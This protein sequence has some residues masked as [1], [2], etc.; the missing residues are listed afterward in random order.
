MNDEL[1]K[2]SRF[3]N[4]QWDTTGSFCSCLT[5]ES[6]YLVP[7]WY[8][9]YGWN[10]VWPALYINICCAVIQMWWKFCFDSTPIVLNWEWEKFAH[11]I[12][13]YLQLYHHQCVS[14]QQPT[15]F[16]W[17]TKQDYSLSIKNPIDFSDHKYFS[18]YIIYCGTWRVN[19]VSCII[20]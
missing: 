9:H 3:V 8:F 14:C 7:C 5:N 6:Q 10:M 1:I 2:V 19:F 15:Q 17:C 12:F 20:V 16:N 18:K 13:L 11:G 4:S